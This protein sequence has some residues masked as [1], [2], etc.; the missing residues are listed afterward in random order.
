MSHAF[1]AHVINP[2]PA[3]A[4]VEN[5]EEVV[6]RLVRQERGTHDAVG[7]IE[8]P[9]TEQILAEPFPENFKMPATKQYE[10]LT[11]PVNH[12][13]SYRTWMNV[14]RATPSIKCQAF[15]LTLTGTALEWFRSLQPRSIDSFDQLRAE[16]ISRFIGHRTR[17]N[18]KTHLWSLKQGNNESLKSYIRRFTK[19]IN[20]VERFTDRDVITALREGLQEGELL[21]S[22]IRKE[23]KTFVEFLNRAQEYIKV[24]DYLHNRREHKAEKKRTSETETGET[25]KQKSNFEFA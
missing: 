24:D 18:D 20:T 14:R 1:A 10:G 7:E 16:F 6:R 13:E 15:E 9:F 22:M 23:P 4:P 17:K 19:E 8:S 5:L 2:A 25:K 21:R 3:A 12:F 11:D